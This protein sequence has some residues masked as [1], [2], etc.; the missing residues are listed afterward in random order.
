[1]TA[2]EFEERTGVRTCNE[3]FRAIHA[4]YLMSDLDKDEFCDWFN[5]NCKAFAREHRTRRA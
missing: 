5:V 4:V 2:R 1:M 3:E